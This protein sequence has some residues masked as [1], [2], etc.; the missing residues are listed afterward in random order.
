[1]AVVRDDAAIDAGSYASAILNILEDSAEET[2]RLG[3]TQ[4]AVLNILEDSAEETA[5]LGDTQRAVL[6]ILEDSAQE[7]ARLGD[8]QRAVLNILE[9]SAQ[10]AARLG[11]T[12]R[13]MLNILEDVDIEKANVERANA[14]LARSNSDLEQFAYVASHDLQE[15][16]RIV[17]SFTE[18]LGRRYKGKLDA[19][20]DEFI[21]F[22]VDGASRMQSMINDL[23]AY[24]RLGSKARSL[25][26][27]DCREVL[28]LAVANLDS[29]VKES[30]ARIATNPLPTVRANAT[31][32]LQLFQNLIANALK[33]RGDRPPVVDVSARLVGTEWIFAVRDNGIGIAPEHVG[34]IFVIF[35]RL[36]PRDRYSGTGIGLAICK[37]VVERHRG[38]IWVDSEP[39]RGSTFSFTIPHT[40]E[41]V[42]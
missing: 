39:G 31:E 42:R 3:D 4:R 36:N 7:T 6:N 2:A 23:L 29:A 38:R 25:E 12:Q 34:R 28:A 21:A 10:E 15:P 8:T 37:K 17:A 41:A 19:D 18:L 40:E 1:M 26:A 16:L 33:F 14:E 30:H 11:D 9:D 22:V 32:L 5:R 24:A 13:A 20:A 35:Q 27:V